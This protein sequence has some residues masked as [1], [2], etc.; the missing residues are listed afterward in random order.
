MAVAAFG[1]P[2]L[3]RS[4]EQRRMV[5]GGGGS[6]SDPDQNLIAH[7]GPPGDSRKLLRLAHEHRDLIAPVPLPERV[8][9]AFVLQGEGKLVLAPVADRPMGAGDQVQLGIPNQVPG[10]HSGVDS[11]ELPRP[12]HR[13]AG[14]LGDEE[15]SHAVNGQEL[16]IVEVPDH[17]VVGEVLEEQGHPVFRIRPDGEEDGLLVDLAPEFDRIA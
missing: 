7:P 3:A 17:P 2:C 10:S 13:L 1:R 16:G 8:P 15:V 4:S 14:L 5:D 11:L 12:G 9:E 6:A